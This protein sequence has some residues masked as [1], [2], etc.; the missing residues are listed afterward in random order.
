MRA[1]L[2][3]HPDRKLV[4]L[5]D[6]PEGERFEG[7][8]WKDRLRKSGA[9]AN[10]PG[11]QGLKG[12]P[13]AIEPSDEPAPKVPEDN[14]PMPFGK[15]APARCGR[16]CQDERRNRKIAAVAG[17]A[18]LAMAAGFG[19]ERWRRRQRAKESTP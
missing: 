1:L 14:S 17:A 10:P 13:G 15:L 18:G 7:D 6:V 3:E 9:T 4:D 5:D 19:W 2:L 12:R 8:D 16:T 11:L